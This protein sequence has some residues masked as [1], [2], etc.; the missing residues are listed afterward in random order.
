[1]TENES[2]CACDDCEASEHPCSGDCDTDDMC[3]GCAQQEDEREEQRFD[4]DC[5]H[6]RY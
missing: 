3:Q 1:M 4:A 2:T 6:G 5:A